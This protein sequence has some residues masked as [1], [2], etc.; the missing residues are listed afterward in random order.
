V[1][2]WNHDL[3]QQICEDIE[4]GL[5]LRAVAEKNGISKAL[6]LKN[7]RAS[8]A[9]GDQYARAME[10]RT[11]ADFEGLADQIAEEPE[12]GKF[13]IDAAWVQWKRLQIDTLKWAL[14]KRNPKKY[15]EKTILAGSDGVGPVEFVTKSILE[16]E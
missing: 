9:F 16:R 6:I 8:K 10:T 3:E 13:G 1:S 5:T 12:R 2:V 4:A 11:D 15:S 7:V 14:S